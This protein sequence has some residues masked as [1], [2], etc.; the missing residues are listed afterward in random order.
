MAQSHSLT[1]SLLLPQPLDRRAQ[2]LPSLT[3][4]SP[5]WLS[6]ALTPESWPASSCPTDPFPFTQ[7][8]ALLGP[9][10]HPGAL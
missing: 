9:G 4:F 6:L 10:L 7:K 5:Q 3:A 8:G 1:H 2:T